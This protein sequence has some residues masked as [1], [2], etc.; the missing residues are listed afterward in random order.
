MLRA[1][2]GALAFQAG[3]DFIKVVHQQ[4]YAGDRPRDAGCEACPRVSEPFRQE[5]R[6]E[7]AADRLHRAAEQRHQGAPHALKRVAE[8]QDHAERDIRGRDR[9]N[10]LPSG[11]QDF[12]RRLHVQEHLQQLF[13]E[14]HH[15]DRSGDRHRRRD[16]PAASHSH[17]DPAVV[18]RAAVL[19]RIGRQ[20]CADGEERDADQAL[21]AA[22]GGGRR[23]GAGSELIERALQDHAPESGHGE[24]QRHW[25]GY[26]QMF[27]VEPPVDAPVGPP[28]GQEFGEL[29]QD[30]GEADQPGDELRCHGRVC[31]ARHVHA[32][33]AD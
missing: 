30:D 1:E 4:H 13:A 28:G 12:R 16:Q 5:H 19:R 33:L 6:R 23:H 9:E 25:H 27:P 29:L 24:L 31:R 15:Q 22:R 17:H 32:V 10:V 7:D 3:T 11:F 20:R 14:D 18:V 2:V 21:E 26:A 8:D